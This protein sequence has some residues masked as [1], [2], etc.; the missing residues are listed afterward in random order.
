MVV[1]YI[2][3]GVELMVMCYIMFCVGKL[4][5]I[6]LLEFCRVMNVI[7]LLVVKVMWLGVLVVGIC[8]VMVS[9]WLF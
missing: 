3:V 6:I 8:L 2:L 5:V 1:I 4:M 7:L 9:V